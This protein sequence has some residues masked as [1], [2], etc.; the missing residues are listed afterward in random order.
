L[1][2]LRL[3]VDCDQIARLSHFIETNARDAGDLTVH[4][5]MVVAEET[6]QWP[7]VSDELIESCRLACKPIWNGGYAPCRS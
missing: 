5:C 3:E 4:P 6:H 1:T 7:Q 2:P